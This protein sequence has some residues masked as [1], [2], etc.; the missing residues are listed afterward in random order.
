MTC[1]VDHMEIWIESA[2]QLMRRTGNSAENRGSKFP[3]PGPV[4]GCNYFEPSLTQKKTVEIFS[5][6]PDGQLSGQKRRVIQEIL[7]S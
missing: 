6:I 5:S 2:R 3:A 1:S 7:R 4:P